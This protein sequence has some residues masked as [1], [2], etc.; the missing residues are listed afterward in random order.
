MPFRKEELTE[1]G[2]IAVIGGIGDDEARRI[3]AGGAHHGRVAEAV[4]I[5]E[6]EVALVMR[7]AAENSARAVFHQH[8]IGNV[9]RQFPCRIK[10]MLRPDASVEALLC[11]R[12]DRLSRG[13]G[14][15]NLLDE[16][17]ASSGF[18]RSPPPWREDGRER[19][20]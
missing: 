5:D 17:L 14:A 13:T 10:G 18:C 2:A 8:K 3:L 1:R 7:R 15:L 6:I 16:G 12:L 9:D 20:P 11:R 4:D 19:S